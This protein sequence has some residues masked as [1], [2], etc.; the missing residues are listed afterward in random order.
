MFDASGGD[1]TFYTQ[2]MLMK[3]GKLLL[4]CKKLDELGKQFWD[5]IVHAQPQDG[6]D[7]QRVSTTKLIVFRPSLTQGDCL[8]G[9]AV[10]MGSSALVMMSSE[11]DGIILPVIHVWRIQRRF[12]RKLWERRMLAAMMGTHERLGV[13]SPFASVPVDLLVSRILPARTSKREK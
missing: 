13:L 7:N 1:S 11:I 9:L 4:D 8:L 10:I 3:V 12:R 5:E 2:S 6:S